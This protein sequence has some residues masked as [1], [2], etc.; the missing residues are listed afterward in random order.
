MCRGLGLLPTSSRVQKAL[1][2]LVGGCWV[3]VSPGRT[4]ASGPTGAGF[5]SWSPLQEQR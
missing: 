1:A 4:Q 3:W 5:W 2:V